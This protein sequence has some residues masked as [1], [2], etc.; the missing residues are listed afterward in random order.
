MKETDLF[1]PIRSWLVEKEWEVY[2]EVTGVG[3]RADV[4]GNKGKTMLNV[5]LKTNLS[6]ELLSQA[7]DRK[8]Y[9]HYIYIAIPKRKTA[10]PKIVRDLL[11]RE[12]IGLIEIENN[13]ARMI[14]PARFNRPP[15]YHRIDWDR[16]L[17]PE[18]KNHVGGDNGSHIQTPYKLLMNEI[19]N[20]LVALRDSDISRSIHGGHRNYGWV[21]IDDILDHCEAHRHYAAP[22]P[23]VSKAIRT[24]EM[25]WC[26]IK[27]EN[28]KLYYRAKDGIQRNLIEID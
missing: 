27:K 6:F 23:S 14:I 26:D 20:Y 16:T 28:R 8:S 24:F 7:I 25:D 5:E 9:F 19:R 3:G 12:N 1:P 21:S 18:Y 2:A 10:V 17:R 4:V 22:K 15:H 13:F 11:K